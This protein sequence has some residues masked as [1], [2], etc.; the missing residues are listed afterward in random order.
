M[1]KEIENRKV[2]KGVNLSQMFENIQ[3]V[4]GN[5]DVA[6]F[7]FKAKG[8]WIDGGYN[9]TTINDFYGAG[10]MQNRSKPFVFDQDEPPILL[11]KDKGANPLEY[12]LVALNGCLTTALIYNASSKGIKIDEVESILEGFLDIHGAMGL[13]ENIRNGY[14]SINVIFR[15]KADGLSDENAKGTFR[16]SP[17]EV[18]GL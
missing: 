9:I 18:T 15:I 2:I 5:S 12:L 7:I 14:Q 6:K 13:D 3:K 11:G 16:Y 1:E 8:K 10:L 17:E 4:K